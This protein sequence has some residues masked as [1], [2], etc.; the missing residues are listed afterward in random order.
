PKRGR[1]IDHSAPQREQ[2]QAGAGAKH[3]TEKPHTTFVRAKKHRAGANG[4]SHARA[5]AEI[6]GRE[7]LRPHPIMRLVEL[8]IG[9][10]QQRQTQARN[11]E[12]KKPD[13]ALDFHDAETGISRGWRA[14]S[15]GSRREMIFCQINSQ[16]ARMS[17]VSPAARK[18]VAATS[19]GQCAPR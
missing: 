16:K 13:R 15:S 10:A 12:E 14:T 11:R 3:W 18:K 17:N 5:L 7:S 6:G 9:R 1:R 8:Q 4:E 19:L 2:K